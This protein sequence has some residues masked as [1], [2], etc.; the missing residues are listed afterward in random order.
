MLSVSLYSTKFCTAYLSLF[1]CSQF[2]I[3][4]KKAQRTLL[5]AVEILVGK[6]YPDVLMSKV[7]HIL[8]SF[9]DED[10]LEEEAI[11][12]WNDKIDKVHLSYDL[13]ESCM[14]I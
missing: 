14:H 13:L 5:D 12:E 6:L 3:D 1:V 10:I 4:N 7:P 9:Y 8:K 11:L 2:V